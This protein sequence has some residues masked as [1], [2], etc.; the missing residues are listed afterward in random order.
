MHTCVAIDLP[1]ESLDCA[2]LI[3]RRRFISNLVYGQRHLLQHSVD[4]FKLIL[5]RVGLVLLLPFDLYTFC[6][7]DIDTCLRE[8]TY[9]ACL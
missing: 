9:M 2:L 3:V 6:A 7:T 5:P 8:Q 4:T 1:S